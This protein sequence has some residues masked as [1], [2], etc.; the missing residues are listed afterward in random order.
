V[1]RTEENIKTDNI[2]VSSRSNQ[3]L[4][5][6]YLQSVKKWSVQTWNPFISVYFHR[7]FST[8]NVYAG[9]WGSPSLLFDVR[10]RF[11]WE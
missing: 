9:S 6:E 8:S 7:F 10:R 1:R 3:R 5:R 4:F 2:L 11:Y